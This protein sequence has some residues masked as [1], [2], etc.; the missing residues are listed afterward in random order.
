MLLPAALLTL[1]TAAHAAGP[2]TAPEPSDI[3]LAVAAVAAVW[4]VRRALRAR[5]RR[6][7]RI[8]D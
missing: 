2:R 1:A 4:F 6:Q 3:A 5:F 7:D 8:A